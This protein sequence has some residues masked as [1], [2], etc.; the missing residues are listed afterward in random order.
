I[1]KI[2]NMNKIIYMLI[3]ALLILLIMS[4]EK[5][6]KYELDTDYFPRIFDQ[7]GVFTS[8]MQVIAAGEAVEY[9]GLVF[10]PAGKVDVTWKVN[11]EEV[12][13]EESYVFSP[14]S[15]GEFEIT[16]EVTNNGKTAV[17]KSKVLVS[18][19]DYTFDDYTKVVMSYLSEEGTVADIDWD[20]VTH[21]TFKAAR[22]IP[23]GELDVTPGETNQVANELVARGHINKK[24]V[25]LGVSG[26]LSGIDGWALYD[27]DD[28]GSVIVDP[29]TRAVLVD[30]LI[31]YMTAKR[32]D[33]IDI[34][35]HDINLSSGH[36]PNM[37]ALGPFLT[38]LRAALDEDKL[39][40]LTVGVGW[41]HWDY[42]ADLSMLD[43]MNVRAFE[44]GL[45]VGP[46]VPTGQPSPYQFMVDGANAWLNGHG[47]PA[48]KLVIGI[49]AFGL[50]YDAL[51]GDGNNLSWGSYGYMP[52]R[53]ILAAD[54]TASEKEYLPN[55]GKGV[56]YNGIPL[57]EQKA[58]YIRD[59][60]FKGAYIWAGDYDV[61]GE[62]SLIKA[63]YETLHE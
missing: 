38:E 13:K 9:T 50:R 27:G 29:A 34:M 1:K 33:G 11:G 31:D 60:N 25:L 19:T 3:P 58:A 56:Y 59:N 40:T 6:E 47:I 55:I 20:I 51:D 10:S 35:M 28:F 44:N 63:L 26:R 48:D 49:P 39:L 52:Y 23:G 24:R 61:S 12:S 41:Q 43:W 32:I 45:T 62:K 16:L 15:G 57:V 22:V 54:A 42:P 2:C 53:E 46:G 21:V 30:N 36:V 14:S 4:C 7:T 5:K 37:Q 17:R 8:P 18:P